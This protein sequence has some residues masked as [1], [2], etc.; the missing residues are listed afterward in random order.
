VSVMIPSQDESI[1]RFR[2]LSWVF[3]YREKGGHPVL[4]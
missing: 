1:V 2:R 4:L 3:P